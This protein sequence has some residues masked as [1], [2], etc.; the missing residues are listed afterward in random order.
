MLFGKKSKSLAVDIVFTVSAFL[1]GKYCLFSSLKNVNE[2]VWEET[3]PPYISW[4]G[5]KT[6]VPRVPAGLTVFETITV[7]L[8]Q[9]FG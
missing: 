6:I 1:S 9:P 3:P 8:S 2:S 4:G 5:E 7:S